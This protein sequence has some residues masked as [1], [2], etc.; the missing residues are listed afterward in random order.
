MRPGVQRLQ[1]AGLCAF[2]DVQSEDQQLIEDLR[3][4][5][6]VIRR[7][8]SRSAGVY[9]LDYLSLNLK[10]AI[11]D[12][13]V[14]LFW[15]SEDAISSPWV[16]EE[17]NHREKHDIPLVVVKVDETPLPGDLHPKTTV[18]LDEVNR[19]PDRVLAVLQS[20]WL[21]ARQR[22]EA[23]V[24]TSDLEQNRAQLQTE[25][26]RRACAESNGTAVWHSSR[27]NRLLSERYE[28]CLLLG[29]PP[30]AEGFAIDGNPI[31]AS[32]ALVG[33]LIISRRIVGPRSKAWP[34]YC[35]KCG[36]M[37]NYA[38]VYPALA[39]WI[40]EDLRGRFPYINAAGCSCP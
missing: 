13:G 1:A 40:D 26:E 16:L 23:S 7:P 18:E 38:E 9:S 28:L 17:R 39:A 14:F 2:L 35:A 32:K 25:C 12:S 11:E 8:G 6:P 4:T 3:K 20:I 27:I 37:D 15:H 22:V 36:G 21:S 29:H 34:R 24:T 30:D 10:D 19:S 5:C 33:N 31:T